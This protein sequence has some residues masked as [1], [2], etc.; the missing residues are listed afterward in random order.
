MDPLIYVSWLSW[1]GKIDLLRKFVS[2][3]YEKIVRESDTYKWVSE[4]VS[5]GKSLPKRSISNEDLKPYINS[6]LKFL[7]QKVLSTKEIGRNCFPE[8]ESLHYFYNPYSN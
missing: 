6:C 2:E 3:N 8:L 5:S 4:L 7:K 1:N